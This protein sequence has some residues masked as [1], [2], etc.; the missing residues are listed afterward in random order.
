M[1][2]RESGM[3][4]EAIWDTF[5]NPAE[6]LAAFGVDGDCGELIEFGCGYGTFTLPAASV[7]SGTVYALD[8]D[9]EMIR[10]TQ[11]KAREAAL[12]NVE[13]RL[14]DFLR[15]GTGLEGGSVDCVLL[16]NI[17]HA[18]APHILLNEAKRILRPQGKLAIIHWRYDPSTP[19]GPSMDIR[20]RPEQCQAWAEEAG[21][22]IL[23]PG[24]IDF[25]PYHYGMRLKPTRS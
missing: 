22:E 17:L 4:D 23:P 6:I 7:V 10:T 8:I 25:P 20:P 13:A 2:T 16:F 3:P 21:F 19:R 18:E 14:R 12:K 24:I 11:V 1:K 9:P 5:F 15:D